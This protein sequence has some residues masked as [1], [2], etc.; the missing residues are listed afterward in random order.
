MKKRILSFL[1]IIG[2][3][4]GVTAGCDKKEEKAIDY[5]A[6]VKLDMSSNSIKEEVTVS[7]YIDGDTTH[8]KVPTSIVD[9][10]VLK[11]RYL[12]V[13]T[14]ESTGKIEEWGKKASNFTKEHL[15]NA[16][17]IIIE[18][19]G[20]E[21]AVDST[22]ERYLVWVWYKTAEMSD[23]RCLNLELLQEGLAVGSKASSTR[24]GDI[25]VKAIDQANRLKLHVHSDES[26]PDFYYGAAQEI[27]L[28]ELR[29]NIANYNGARVAF[30]GVVAQYDNQGVYVEEYDLETDMYY[31]IYVYYGFFLSNE[32]E[33]VLLEGNRV[34]VVGVV[35]Y[36]ET[37]M[38]YQISDL[39]YDPFE[40]DDPENIQLLSEGHA[41]AN[42][43]TSAETFLGKT[44][45]TIIDEEGEEQ[46]E[47]RDYAEVAINSSISMKN[48]YV[49]KAYTTNNG[50][51]N[52]GAI[53]LTCTVDGKTVVVRTTKLYNEDMS[54][55]TQDRYLGK[56]IDVVGIIDSFD[57]EYQI[58][59]FDVN[60]IVIH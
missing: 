58:K 2:M 12:A 57:G 14:P 20:T 7:A 3:I 60:D 54:L 11:A 49:S 4:L 44:T 36:W 53:T 21:W 29:L 30:E 6:Q 8:F 35:S 38:T 55:V 25:A 33:D 9:T 10:G 48:L 24:Y 42:P 18:T 28:K 19:D 52:D 59:V 37:G 31:G 32:G 34:R 26:D 45:V 27:E 16:T 22:G 17:S 51:N 1:L 39:D 15:K 23:Y 43:E 5:A 40:P 41:A 13:N 47:T 56:T 50:G 46:S